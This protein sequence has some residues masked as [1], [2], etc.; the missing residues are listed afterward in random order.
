MQ[1]GS[2]AGVSQPSALAQPLL[3]FPVLASL[4]NRATGR[5]VRRRSL[6]RARC[7][8]THPRDPPSHLPPPRTG[9]R[10]SHIKKSIKSLSRVDSVVPVHLTGL[11]TITHVN[12]AATRRALRA[13][14][15]RYSAH[16]PGSRL[17]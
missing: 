3:P 10:P 7:A 13:L 5:R 16:G 17:W 12:S 14:E 15:V 4:S 11:K 2:S 9:E 8:L 6:T 1:R